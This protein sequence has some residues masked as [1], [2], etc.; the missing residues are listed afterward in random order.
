MDQYK[1]LLDET[2]I[3]I[4]PISEDD[5]YAFTEMLNI[6]SIRVKEYIAKHVGKTVVILGFA[7]R[8]F[9]RIQTTVYEYLSQDAKIS[10]KSYKYNELLLQDG[11]NLIYCPN[12]IA[13][14]RGVSGDLFIILDRGNINSEHIKSIIAPIFSNSNAYY[15]ILKRKDVAT[16]TFDRNKD[17][18]E[19][20][21]QSFL[22]MKEIKLN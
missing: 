8:D 6:L 11:T 22:A 12:N 21:F 13:W 9:S 15:L 14:T 18:F 3:V 16:I 7:Q 4:Q 17:K 1:C 19:D 20:F 10:I 5:Y 2:K